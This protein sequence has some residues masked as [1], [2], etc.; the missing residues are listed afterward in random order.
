MK[1][2]ND[3]I[4]ENTEALSDN[5]DFFKKYTPL[6][7]KSDGMQIFNK[8][9]RPLNERF[10]DLK[11]SITET[12]SDELRLIITQLGHHE[13]YVMVWKF[14]MDKHEAHLVDNN[15]N[16]LKSLNDIITGIE[17]SDM[18]TVAQNE[19]SD[20]KTFETF[21]TTDGSSKTSEYK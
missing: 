9:K 14:D 16:V 21:A 8:A 10:G 17:A 20:V 3:F 1:K 4:F 5:N 19:S 6:N 15:G 11:F 12:G 18:R 13:S 2:Y 7:W